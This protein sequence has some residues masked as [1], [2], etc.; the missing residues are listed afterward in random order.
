MR[1]YI[2]TGLILLAINLACEEKKKT[3]RVPATETAKGIVLA[4][5]VEISLP[6]VQTDTTEKPATPEKP[7]ILAAK[8]APP[9]PSPVQYEDVTGR[10]LAEGSRDEAKDVGLA[11]IKEK[12]LLR[13]KELQGVDDDTEVSAR[14]GK[15]VAMAD[16]EATPATESATPSVLAPASPASR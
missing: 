8:V 1:R 12:A 15:I 5:P 16:P 10:L 2:V 4:N 11:K 13:S 3:V 6:S 9:V 7:I 14:A